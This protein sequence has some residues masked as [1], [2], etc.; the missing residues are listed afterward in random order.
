M[1][2]RALLFGRA[3]IFCFGRAL[4]VERAFI[5]VVWTRVY[6]VFGR[7]SICCLNARFCC[8]VFV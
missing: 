6:Y 5:V 3:L 2:G 7:A 8:F 4:F 1:V